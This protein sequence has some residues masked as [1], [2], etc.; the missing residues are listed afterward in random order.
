MTIER[1]MFPP[2]R[3]VETYEP[4]PIQDTFCTTLVRV[5][6]LGPCLRLVFAVPD[7]A[8]LAGDPMMVVIGK[9]VVPADQIAAIAAKLLDVPAEVRKFAHLSSDTTAH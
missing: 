2:R 4:C 1:P 3:E 8:P 7:S 5:E 9:I 6:R